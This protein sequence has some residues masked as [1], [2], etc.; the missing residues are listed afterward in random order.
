MCDEKN[1]TLAGTCLWSSGWRPDSPAPVS[2]PSLHRSD[3]SS[4]NTTHWDKKYAGSQ[5][6]S[7]RFTL[8]NHILLIAFYYQSKLS[9]HAVCPFYIRYKS[10]LKIFETLNFALEFSGSNCGGLDSPVFHRWVAC[11]TLTHTNSHLV[12]TAVFALHFSSDT[13]TDTSRCT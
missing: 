1:G 10:V 4:L 12:I 6:G 5:E 3:P 11:P 7:F 8:L 2:A 13:S 9:L